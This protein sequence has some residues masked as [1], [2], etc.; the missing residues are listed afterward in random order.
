M[1]TDVYILSVGTLASVTPE[2]HIPGNK[3]NMKS[4]EMSP[5]RKYP[6]SNQD[7]NKLIH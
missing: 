4:P 2:K 3:R 7:I 6:I 5:P 1:R